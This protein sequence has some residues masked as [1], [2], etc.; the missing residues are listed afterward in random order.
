M[1]KLKIYLHLL[2]IISYF[3]DETM[4]QKHLL[5]KIQKRAEF[6]K[7]VQKDIN[8]NKKKKTRKL[9]AGTGT[10]ASATEETSSP[11]GAFTGGGGAGGKKK[12]KRKLAA[13]QNEDSDNHDDDDDDDSRQIEA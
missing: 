6:Q 7:T 8:E 4:D 5:R 3:P 12:K 9:A 11:I 2:K 1:G 13:S 10:G